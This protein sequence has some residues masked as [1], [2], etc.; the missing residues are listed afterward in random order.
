LGRKQPKRAFNHG[1]TEDI[2]SEDVA[3]RIQSFF[4]D[5]QNIKS[6]NPIIL[7]VCKEEESLNLLRNMGVDTAGWRSG[8]RDLLLPDSGARVHA[9]P[10]RQAGPSHS[11]QLSYSGSS[12]SSARQSHR[13]RSRSRSPSRQRESHWRDSSISTSASSQY[14]RESPVAVRQSYAP[15]YVLDV[16][17]LYLKL[18][19][20]RN[21][22]GVADIARILKVTDEEG[23]CAGNE[24]ATIINIWKEM[25]S[26]LPID[27]QRELRRSFMD[28]YF[29]D[30]STELSPEPEPYTYNSDDDR[31]PNEIVA[32]PQ[33]QS[34]SKNKDP[35]QFDES[36]SDS[37]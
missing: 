30:S 27:D 1:V 28:P 3:K 32:Q 21:V 5:H 16:R 7:L 35:Y 24:A 26:S 15:V 6:S 23:W 14:Y 11:R 22:R 36:D 29:D 31:D 33:A 18:M 12:Y 8:I 9:S 2:A 20:A 13:N 17:E 34:S 10:K 19:Q 37:D 25:I 4:Q